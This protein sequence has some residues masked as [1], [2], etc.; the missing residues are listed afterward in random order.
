MIDID[1]AEIKVCP[2]C[3]KPPQVT[4]YLVSLEISSE[5][6]LTLF[7]SPMERA[8]EIWNSRPVEEA[9]AKRIAE[10]GVQP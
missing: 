2:C 6:G 3:G 10:L 8:V 7:A 4:R 5:C 1:L 9:L